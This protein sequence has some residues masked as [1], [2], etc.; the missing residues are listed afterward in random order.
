M[1]SGR[2]FMW[3]AGHDLWTPNFVSD[4][5]SLLERQPKACLAFGGSRWIGAD[6]ESLPI[7]SGWTDTRGLGTVARLFTIFWGNMHPVVGLIR[8]EDLRACLP[9]H[10]L[11]GGD[12]V[13]L[14]QLGLRG[15]FVH[16][17]AA[18]WSRREFRM[19]KHHSEKLKRYASSS[20]GI[21]RSPLG[22]IFP[23][24]ELPIALVKVLLK[25]RLPTLDKA[26]ALSVLA[27][28]FPLRYRVGRRGP[29]A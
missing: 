10:Q 2:Y 11:A 13:L 1:A 26:L 12:L 19:E 8:T 6:G 28:S 4:C 5:V 16:A 14:M 22:R 20:T 23:M 21:V 17:T 24:L 7:E 27:P 15:N 9:L 3:A 18:E 29:D 25:S